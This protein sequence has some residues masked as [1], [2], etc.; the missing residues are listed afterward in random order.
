MQHRRG[1]HEVDA[2]AGQEFQL[3]NLTHCSVASPCSRNIASKL[4]CPHLRQL[5]LQKMILEFQSSAS[6]FD[7][8]PL[9]HCTGLTALHLQGCLVD[10]RQAASAAIAA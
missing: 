5:Q 8:N 9:H 1:L 2:L 6:V 7:P 3:P 4:P 10:D